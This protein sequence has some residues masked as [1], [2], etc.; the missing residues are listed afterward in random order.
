M[1]KQTTTAVSELLQTQRTMVLAT[2]DPHP[3][4]APVYFVCLQRKFYFFSSPNSRHITA[5]LTSGSCAA[6]VFRDSE[7]WRDIEGLQ[8]DGSIEEIGFG[9]NALA[10]FRAY[11]DKFPTV[12]DFFFDAAFDFAQFRER[13][14]TQLYA[15]APQHAFYLNNEAGLAKRQQIE[16]PE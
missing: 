16:L 7:H 11:V 10:A 3:W 5:A 9:A 6:S 12:K 13:F 14:R 8:M 15:F 1:P 2:T 4:S